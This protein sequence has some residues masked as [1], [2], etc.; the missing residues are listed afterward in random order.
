MPN[1][2]N[3]NYELQV[4]NGVH[5]AE[6][7]ISIYKTQDVNYGMGGPRSRGHKWVDVSR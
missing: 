4:L 7:D 1:G 6:E 2:C 3:K 5:D